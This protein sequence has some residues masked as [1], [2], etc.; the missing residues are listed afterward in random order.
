MASVAQAQLEQAAEG[1][2]AKPHRRRSLAIGES[3]CATRSPPHSDAEDVDCETGTCEATWC[4][5]AIAKA[6]ESMQKWSEL[7]HTCRIQR[8]IASSAGKSRRSWVSS[9]TLRCTLWLWERAT[10]GCNLARRHAARQ[11]IVRVLPAW[12]RRIVAGYLG[13]VMEKEKEVACKK[14]NNLIHRCLPRLHVLSDIMWYWGQ[15]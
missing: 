14:G 2:G 1:A 11:L 7:S 5:D 4:S 6:R 15:D 9:R 10:I 3:F 8:A 12:R 13:Y